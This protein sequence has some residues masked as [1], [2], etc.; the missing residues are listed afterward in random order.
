M[1]VHPP[2]P[3]VCGSRRRRAASRPSARSGR[4]GSAGAGRGEADCCLIHGGLQHH[5]D[6]GLQGETSQDLDL[7][8]GAAAALDV[9]LQ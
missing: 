2:P 1:A 3:P 4:A 8:L 7:E 9:A 5:V 6:T